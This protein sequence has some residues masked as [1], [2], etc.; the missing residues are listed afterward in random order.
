MFDFSKLSFTYEP[1]PIGFGH[2]VFSSEFYARMVKDYPPVELHVPAGKTGKEFVLDAEFAPRTFRDFVSTHSVWREFRDYFTSK[3]FIKDTLQF[4]QRRDI[5]LGLV[6]SSE[7]NWKGK[8]EAVLS[9]IMRGHLPKGRTQLSSRFAFWSESVDGACIMPHTDAVSKII[10]LCLPVVKEGSWN[11]AWGG[12]TEM[13]RMKDPTKS[14]NVI[15][16]RVDF[17]AAE[18]IASYPFDSNQCLLFIKTFNSLHCV[19]PMRG[20]DRS[21]LRKMLVVN[22]EAS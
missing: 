3:L 22:I 6:T 5:D 2:G 15:N 16:K 8:I 4:L 9:Q 13:M 19:K 17:D 14:F 20:N 18:T 12:A 21:I 1:F 7:L 10:T 11:Q